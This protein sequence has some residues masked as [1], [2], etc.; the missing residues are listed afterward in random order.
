MFMQLT[1]KLAS[2]VADFEDAA[3]VATL[4]VLLFLGLTLSGAAELPA[5]HEA[6]CPRAC[7]APC[8]IRHLPPPSVGMR[9]GFF[10]THFKE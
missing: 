3:G 7:P 10:S 2:H 6:L 4:F 5:F 8:L 9:G 1:R